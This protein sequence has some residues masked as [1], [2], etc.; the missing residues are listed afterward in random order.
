[1]RAASCVA[2]VAGMLSVLAC[3]RPGERSPGGDAVGIVLR[4][5]LLGEISIALSLEPPADDATLV[6]QFATVVSK[7]LRDCGAAS[8]ALGRRAPVEV[9]FD[10]RERVLA[11]PVRTSLPDEASDRCVAA[12]FEG[13]RIDALPP[14]TRTG[15]LTF[16]LA[17]GPR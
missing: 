10:V 11:G 9:R 8:P 16:R 13:Q 5:P 7:A 17:T 14:T 3:G 6:A 1:V 2:F 12:R 4:D 15:Q